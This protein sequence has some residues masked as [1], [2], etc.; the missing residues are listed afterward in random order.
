M[1]FT[2]ITSPNYPKKYGFQDSCSWT[3]T[4]QDERAVLLNFTDFDTELG[5]DPLRIYN[6]SNDNG[7]KLAVISGTATPSPM[8]RTGTTYLKFSSDLIDS[9]KGFRIL[10]TFVG[11]YTLV[12]NSFIK[13]IHLNV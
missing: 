13:N 1:A 11:K 6:G 4:T 8:W 7:I 9:R 10:L 12:M 5:L 3:I 2:N